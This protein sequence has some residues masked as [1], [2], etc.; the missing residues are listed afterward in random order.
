MIASPTTPSV[1]RQVPGHDGLAGLEVLTWPAFGGF[2]MDV[3]VTTRR[4]GVSAGPYASLNL[5]LNVGD[6]P[7]HVLENRRRA[8]AALGPAWRMPFSP[9]RCTARQPRWSAGRIGAAAPGGPPTP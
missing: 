5:S 8:L 1:F 6:D 7:A 9:S 2:D 3:L 4:G